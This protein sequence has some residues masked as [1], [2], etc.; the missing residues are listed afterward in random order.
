MRRNRDRDRAQSLERRI[1]GKTIE[2]LSYCALRKRDM[3][4]RA[5]ELARISLIRL[6]DN[7][8]ERNPDFISIPKLVRR[9]MEQQNECV[10]S[11]SVQQ[12]KHLAETIVYKCIG[13]D[14]NLYPVRA[15]QK[16]LKSKSRGEKE[17]YIPGDEMTVKDMI[18]VASAIAEGENFSK[19][20]MQAVFQWFKEIGLDPIQVRVFSV[21]FIKQKP[22]SIKAIPMQSLFATEYRKAAKSLVE[23]GYIC[24]FPG[25]LYCINETTLA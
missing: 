13:N 16:L 12:A 15:D 22:V 17:C 25:E 24:E 20:T 7:I 6:L 18:Y 23:K 2:I 14:L 10:A 8:I 9:S 4:D 19:P 1:S 21:L 3:T 11:C 5:F